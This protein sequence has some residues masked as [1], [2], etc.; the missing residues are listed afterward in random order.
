MEHRRS[1]EHTRAASAACPHDP[2]RSL[3]I[4]AIGIAH[5]SPEGVVT[6]ANTRLCELLGYARNDIIGRTTADLTYP[7][8]VDL[9]MSVRQAL[10][11]GS[12][13]S[14]T[15]EKR[16]L[17]RDGRV[18]WVKRWLS[19]VRDATAAPLHIVAAYDDITESKLTAER[20]RAI[21]DNAAVGITQVRLDGL[22]VN[23]NDK[24]CEMLGYSRAELRGK[25]I[26]EITHPEDYGTGASFRE[27][28]VTG[29]TGA[30][31]GEKRFVRKSGEVIWV[32]RTMS[33]VRD[34][35]GAPVFV[36]SVVEDV[37]ERKRAEEALRLSEQ[38]LR[39]TFSQA[40]V[41][42]L[43]SAPDLRI[44]HVND[45]YCDLLGYS[46]AELL[47]MT[48]LAINAGD[49][50]AEVI[51]NRDRLLRGEIDNASRERQLM[52]KDGTPIWLGHSTSL[53][54]DHDGKVQHFVTV[55]Q[56]IR[57]RKAA[58]Q[59]LKQLAHYD[60]LTNLPNRVLFY[61]R[62]RSELAQALHDGSN[63]AVLFIDVDRFKYVNDTMGHAAG[64][65][66]LKLVGDRLS[67]AVRARDT[68]G[69]LGGDEFAVVAANLKQSS[70]ARRVA[71]K[72]IEAFNDPVEV[73]GMEL[74]VTAS[75]G[76]TLCPTD[77]TDPD[78]L[79]RNADAAMYRAK[80]LGR[81]TY[82]FYAPD[83]NVH[84]HAMITLGN[85]LRHALERGEFLLH[86][87]PKV[88]L[89]TG[90]LTGFE[91]LL[92][93]QRADGALLMPGEFVHVLEETGHI[94]PVGKWVIEEACR[95]I[96][97]WRAAG[98]APVRI[99]VNLSP[100]QFRASQLAVTVREILDR[101]GVNAGLLQLEITESFLANRSEAVQSVQA[102][103]EAGISIA[104]DDFGTGYSNL[105]NL[106][107]FAV[108][109]V[110]IDRSFV[111]DIDTDDDDA[112]IVRAIINMAHSLNLAVVAEGVENE[113][114]LEF[115]RQCRCDE[116]QGYYVAYPGIAE[117]Q[118]ALLRSRIHAGTGGT[119]VRRVV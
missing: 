80:D 103:T 36:I 64:D 72:I 47:D 114:Q 115:L 86:Y 31:A 4:A 83:I 66:L 32:R 116:V 70:D 12:I 59:K 57:E 89:A 33:V 28:I 118:L 52:R 1:Q 42:I 21:F 67:Q 84:A 76:I 65:R 13:A 109:T 96:V 112:A 25:T 100:R 104:I 77:S 92:R 14:K 106:K 110:K 51:A 60:G 43:I 39:T 26:R 55:A 10:V 23:V 94:V 88:R 2:G 119:P 107:R 95:Q 102:L 19:L 45:K 3:D 38:I 90:E 6:Y 108:D 18:I 113:A 24:F 79:I 27:R 69:R 7:A 78:M 44:L 15:D 85:E 41:G 71:Q 98:I 30:I 81:N 53:V 87:Q 40:G 63:M 117:E 20:Y 105:A 68:V 35:V 62:L 101:A 111:R 5:V 11:S 49:D 29:E 16:L 54:R 48:I 17:R 9:E 74:Y 22:L 75:V 50:M 37:S 56:D 82:E 91:A 97:A 93:W 73:D 99:A 61:E 58:E 46:R 8:D 34:N